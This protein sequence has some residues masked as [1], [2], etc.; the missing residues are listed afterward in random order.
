MGKQIK[1]EM[2]ELE[3]G[4]GGVREGVH[5]DTLLLSNRAALY[6]PPP[7]SDAPLHLLVLFIVEAV[8]TKEEA[9]QTK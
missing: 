9:G 2:G 1:P 6:L 7:P 8:Q 4:G 5:S 3:R